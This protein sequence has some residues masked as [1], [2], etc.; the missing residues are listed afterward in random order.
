MRTHSGGFWYPLDPRPE[1][2]EIEDI[3]HNLAHICRYGGS[4]RW[5]YSV[6]EHSVLVSE[7]LPAEYQLHGLLHD[8]AEAVVGDMVSPLK[9]R[10]PDFAEIEQQVLACIFA[11]FGVIWTA[12]ATEAV[13]R[14]DHAIVV[15]ECLELVTDGKQYLID[16]GRGVERL[17]VNVIG[18]T[19]WAA[20]IDFLAQFYKL[21]EAK[22]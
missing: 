2:F 21:M 16:S 12:E 18:M 6:A 3:A 5:H 17:G 1:D 22:R 9:A 10:M 19:P 15:D 20:K 7:S 8:A 14:V 13:G 11:R 4:V